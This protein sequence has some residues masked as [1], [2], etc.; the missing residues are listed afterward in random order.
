[1]RD[2]RIDFLACQ[3]FGGVVAQS[4]AQSDKGLRIRRLPIQH[5]CASSWAAQGSMDLIL[6]RLRTIFASMAMVPIR[7]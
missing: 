3:A 5:S 4:T 7:S 2:Q 6:V 1:M